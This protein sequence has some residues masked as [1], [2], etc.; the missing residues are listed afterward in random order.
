MKIQQKIWE[1]KTGWVD[2][3]TEFDSVSP[4]LVFVFGLREL[5][6]DKKIFL[7]VKNF[8]PLANIICCSTA[9]EISELRVRENSLAVTALE[10]EKTELKFIEQN[11]KNSGESFEVGK[12]LAEGLIKSDL[13]HV[14]VF[15]DGLNVNGTELVK[16]VNS[17]LPE[18]VS[19]TG[20]LVADGPDF[21]T[22]ALGLNHEGLSNKVVIIGFYGKFLK[23]GYGSL[24]GWDAFGVERVVTKSKGNILYELDSKPALK[25]YKEYL[26][27][28]AAGLPST[29]LLFPLK[30]KVEDSD[31]NSEVV[32]TILAVNEAEQS[33]TFAGDI[34]EGS[35]ATLM[36]ANFERLIDGASQA[37]NLTMQSLD[38]LQPEFALLISCVGR[39][40]VLKERAE[41]EVEAVSSIFKDKAKISGFYSY[42]EL[43]P[44]AA[45]NKQCLLH[46]QTM[47][48]TAFK[49]I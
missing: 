21:K 28:K 7:E 12:V 9:G 15:S 25:L 47:T 42:G 35:R 19:V 34:P 39:K 13:V 3:K 11:I 16:G 49:E 20:G 33:M 5:V 17:A 23:V 8:Y 36:K 48:I 43:C 26:G 45:S 44:T 10:F 37:G 30:L 1:R 27:E 22:T 6:E 14:M 38:N 31:Q 46:N 24:G 40:L 32:R 29:G 4:Q 41:E 18:G 2:V